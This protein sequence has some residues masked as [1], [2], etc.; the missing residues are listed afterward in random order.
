[1]EVIALM[2][3]KSEEAAVSG[4][5]VFQPTRILSSSTSGYLMEGVKECL[6]VGKLNIL[7]DLRNVLFMDSSGLAALV[8]VW[9]RVKLARGRFALCNVSG[10]ARMLLEQTGMGRT[11]E[12]YEN[13]EDFRLEVDGTEPTADSA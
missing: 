10:Q 9:K 5:Q 12:I 6:E 11:F 7:V 3:K 2:S 8:S 13:E 1:M 4:I